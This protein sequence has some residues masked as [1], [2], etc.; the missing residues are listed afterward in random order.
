MVAQDIGWL[1]NSFGCVILS[2]GNELG[3]IDQEGDIWDSTN[4]NTDSS[5]ENRQAL[6]FTH[7]PAVSLA[8]FCSRT[9]VMVL[10][11]A[12]RDCLQNLINQTIRTHTSHFG[13]INKPMKVAGIL[14][15]S[16]KNRR[17]FHVSHHGADL[18][19][20]SATFKDA[21][22]WERKAGLSNQYSL[23]YMSRVTCV[24]RRL[25]FRFLFPRTSR[26]G[27]MTSAKFAR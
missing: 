21:F 24:P 4:T 5:L 7:F 17:W 1:L 16:D 25:M 10:G 2:D 20:A 6:L 22:F 15:R 18:N 8:C 23:K 27:L 11:P 12:A 14:T 26:A 13:T 9:A 3:K 19:C